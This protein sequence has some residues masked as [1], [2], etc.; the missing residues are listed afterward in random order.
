MIDVIPSVM[1]IEE[2]S[3][4]EAGV[5][6]IAK[7]IAQVFEFNYLEKSEVLQEDG[8]KDMRTATVRLDG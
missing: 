7:S 8:L 3:A 6:A 5:E 1:N 4:L 2:G